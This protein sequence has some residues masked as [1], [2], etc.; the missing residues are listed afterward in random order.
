[1][2]DRGFHHARDLYGSARHVGSERFASLHCWKSFC[3]N[4]RSD[5]G[6][7][8]L[9]AF[10]RD[11]SSGDQL[12]RPGFRS[13]TISD[14][15]HHFVHVRVGIVRHRRKSWIPNHSAR[16]ARRCRRRVATDLASS[17]DGEFSAGETR[18]GHGR[19]HHGHCGRANSGAD[20]RWLANLQLLL[21]VGLLY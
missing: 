5:L 7:D 16:A 11:H 20:N 10:E 4:R 1:M 21:A 6:F 17:P 8:Q 3:V 9:S 18:N 13:K 19:F 14:W 15:L 12:V 2:G